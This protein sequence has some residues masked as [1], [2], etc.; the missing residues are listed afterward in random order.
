MFP[1]NCALL[2]TEKPWLDFKRTSRHKKNGISRIFTFEQEWTMD[3]RHTFAGTTV[4]VRQ[5]T[6]IL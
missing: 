2:T 4:L 6:L 1:K 5:V 3:I